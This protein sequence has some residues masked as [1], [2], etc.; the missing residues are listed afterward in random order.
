MTYMELFYKAT[1]LIDNGEITL[2][3]YEE[4][5]KPLDREIEQEPYDDCCNGNQIEKAKLCQKSYIAGMEHK[6]EPKWDRLYSWL[7]DMRL[8][9]APDETV[10]DVDERNERTAQVD[11][12]D[13]IMEWIEKAVWKKK[14]EDEDEQGTN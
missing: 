8:G 6:Q 11:L 1:R 7:N 2:G 9:I 4:M 5:T 13:E 12:L 3:E 10:T 14:S